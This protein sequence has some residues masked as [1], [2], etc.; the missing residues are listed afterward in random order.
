MTRYGY[1]AMSRLTSLMDARGR[2]TRFEYDDQGQLVRQVFPDGKDEGYS[3]TVGGRLES[4]TDRRGIITHYGYDGIGRLVEQT[5]SDGTPSIRLSYDAAG[6]VATTSNGSDALSW[7]YDAAGRV[8][9]ESSSAGSTALV[10]NYDAVGRRSSGG[11]TGSPV[12][13]Y[14]YDD[15]GRLAG[16]TRG[17]A[18]F[19]IGYD[20]ADRRT[21]LTFPNGVATSYGY[22]SVDRLTELVAVRGATI[23]AS[24][25][26]THDA[27]ANRTSKTAPGLT[28]QYGYD[29]LDRLIRVDRPGATA[30]RSV[31][32]YDPVGNR[33]A[34][35]TGTTVVSVTHDSGNRL[36]AEAVGG[37]LL[38]RGSLNEAGSVTVNCEAA[39]LLA[40][41]VFEATIPANP[42]TNAV[43]V[44]ATDGQGNARTSRYEV[45]V[46]GRDASY[47]YDP[48][49]N[50][51]RKIEGEHDW[52]YEWNARNQLVRV[53]R[54]GAEM[55][56]FAYDPL[57]RRIQKL[58]GGVT[59]GYVYDGEDILRD[60]RS[61][62]TTFTYVHGPGIDEPLARIDGSG[63]TEYYHTDGLA[64]I[65]RTTDTAGAVRLT[66]QYDAWGNLEVGAE[67]PG[68][69]FTGREWDPETG[70]YYF[71]A[72]YYDPK[73]GRF[74][75]EDPIGLIGGINLYRYVRN[76]PANLIDPFGLYDCPMPFCNGQIEKALREKAKQFC[77]DLSKP[78][79]RRIREELTESEFKE[80]RDDATSSVRGSGILGD[81]AQR[82]LNDPKTPQS[83][84][85]E[86]QGFLNNR[87]KLLEKAK[88]CDAM[89]AQGNKDPRPPCP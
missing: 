38:V 43:T 57:G 65:V 26:Y 4:K 5:F 33:T 17:G 24:H 89:R 47:I 70:L 32:T 77:Q 54:D 22:D 28:E 34:T 71:R 73:T 52:A 35:Q 68:Y 39:R 64:S 49:G 11:L 10:S 66:R 79:S 3:Y 81:A 63:A 7:S 36:T 75:S 55:A 86:L 67:Q 50:L 6:R 51:T 12:T 74:I 53:A 78:G 37:P 31:F 16:L 62:G 15:A 40:E 9:T 61:D 82:I 27:A 21:S 60:T 1:D 29:A 30:E 13:I 85:D 69:A 58:A 20:E 18:S 48:A 44:V 56:R 8:L 2:T 25:G 19:A 76:N 23:V 84:K 59:T 88:Q 41:N 87:E 72:R 45:D 80:A 42:G 14:S 83:V 46:A